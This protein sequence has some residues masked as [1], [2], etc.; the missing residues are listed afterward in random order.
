MTNQVSVHLKQ[1]SHQKKD[2]NILIHQQSY[3]RRFFYESV[4]VCSQLWRAFSPFAL[5]E[6]G[7]LSTTLRLHVNEHEQSHI[8]YRTTHFF[9]VSTLV[10]INKYFLT[11]CTLVMIEDKSGN[12]DMK[13]SSFFSF[14]RNIIWMALLILINSLNSPLRHLNADKFIKIADT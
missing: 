1:N 5:N 4:F 12:K 3:N 14:S 13:K 11:V 9:T 8:K 7:G 2:K 6:M 10:R